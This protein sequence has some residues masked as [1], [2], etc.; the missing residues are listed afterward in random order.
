MRV[1]VAPPQPLSAATTLGA[2][3]LVAADAVGLAAFYQRALGLRMLGRDGDAIA[4]GVDPDAPLVELV[5]RPEAP[6]APRPSTGL[7]HLALLV[8]DRPALARTVR[9][10]IDRGGGLTGASD[11]LVS[12]AL[13]LRD[14]EGNGIEV[15]RDRPR[16]QWAHGP[17]GVRMD[18]L[19]LD[20]AGLLAEVASGVESEGVPSGTRLGHVHLQVA[21][22]AAAEDFYAGLLGLRVTVRSYGGALFLS[23]GGYHHHI[24]VNTWAGEG[25]PAPPP[26]ARGLDRFEVLVDPSELEA[27]AE[28]LERA[29]RPGEREGQAL[30]A[31]DPSG[32]R[33]LLRAR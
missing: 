30:L 18:T 8:P 10:L 11:H 2:V 21:N 25:A 31:T 22:L 14:P 6:P 20:V 33:V 16:E 17:D 32:N 23:A 12:E 7:F 27:V 3:R 29:G 9:R 28:R 19:A 5:D 1:S 26:S 4:L 15:Y 13:Y 24:G